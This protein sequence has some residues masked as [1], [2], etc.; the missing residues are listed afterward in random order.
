VLSRALSEGPVPM[1]PRLKTMVMVMVSHAV[2]CLDFQ[3][4]GG[5]LVFLVHDLLFHGVD[6]H[7][8]RSRN[9]CGASTPGSHSDVHQAGMLRGHQL[10]PTA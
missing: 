10:H 2:R 7:Q 9:V 6:S 3:A 8:C 4:T 5:S 1:R